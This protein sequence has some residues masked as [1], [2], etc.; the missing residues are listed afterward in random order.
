M[1]RGLVVPL[2][3]RPCVWNEEL[4]WAPLWAGVERLAYKVL[5][6]DLHARPFLGAVVIQQ[7]SSSIGTLV[8]CMLIGGQQRLTTLQLLFDAIHEEIYCTGLVNKA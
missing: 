2:F 4:Q 7:E 3:Q 8:T 5:A 6:Q 1:P